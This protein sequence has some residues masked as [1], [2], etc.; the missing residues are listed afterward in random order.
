MEHPNARTIPGQLLRHFLIGVGTPFATLIDLDGFAADIERHVGIS[1]NRIY[2]PLITL[3]LFLRQVADADHS[4]LAAVEHLAAARTAAKLS[5]C[6]PDTGAYCKAR[7]RLPQAL[8][9]D[10]VR[11]TGARLQ[12][13]T[14]DV[15]RFHGRHVKIVDGTGCSMPDTAA[16]RREFGLG[17]GPK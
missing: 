16:S 15:Q 1:R 10:L 14:P 4:C 5:P 13:R 3:A 2:T 9:K 6:S 12:R 17:P 11:H 7:H 8:F